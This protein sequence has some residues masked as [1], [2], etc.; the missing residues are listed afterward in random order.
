ME[1]LF[2][3]LIVVSRWYGQVWKKRNEEGRANLKQ[4][5]WLVT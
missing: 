5:I 1:K 2:L 4:L 3:K